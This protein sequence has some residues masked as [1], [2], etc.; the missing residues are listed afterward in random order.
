MRAA[1]PVVERMARAG[2][3]K[4]RGEEKDPILTSERKEVK[5]ISQLGKSTQ[6]KG[7]KED[8]S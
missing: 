3:R 1:V 8:C 7:I 4:A 6:A 2:G 5:K